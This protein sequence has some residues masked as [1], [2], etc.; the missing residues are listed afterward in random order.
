M[1]DVAVPLVSTVKSRALGAA[2][3]RLIKAK[4]QTL[5]GD[6]SGTVEKYGHR[7]QTSII[8]VLRLWKYTHPFILHPFGADV[9]G[10]WLEGQ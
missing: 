10:L 5:R 4:G 1:G 3:I 6:K 8:L 7:D 9:G 2:T